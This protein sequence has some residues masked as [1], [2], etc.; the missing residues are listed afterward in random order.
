MVRLAKRADIPRLVELRDGVGENGLTDP[1]PV[2]EADAARFI[3]NR[4]FWVWQE[5]DGAIAGFAGSDAAAGSIW[6]LLVAPGHE[7]KGIGRAL[8]ETACDG[9]REAGH[10]SAWLTTS[11]GSRAERHYRAAGWI[12]SGYNQQG[13]LVMRK[14]L[15]R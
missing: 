6:A 2:S 5:D 13:E 4:T 8:L 7:G 14:P 1:G 11:A 12:A 10:R 3:A 9:L 15:E